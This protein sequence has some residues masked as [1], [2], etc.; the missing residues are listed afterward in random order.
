ML[1]RLQ[2]KC[3]NRPTMMLFRSGTG[4][5]N[6]HC[7][8]TIRYPIFSEEDWKMVIGSVFFVAFVIATGT[9]IVFEWHQ[10]VLYG[11]NFKRVD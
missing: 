11:P 8:R 4:D 2:Q 5:S 7:G 6:H 3:R 9:A 10:D 1:T